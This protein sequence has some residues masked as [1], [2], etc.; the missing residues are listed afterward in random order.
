MSRSPS[1]IPWASSAAAC[2]RGSAGGRQGPRPPCGVLSL[3]HP[4]GDREDERARGHRLDRLGDQA[5]AL[6]DVERLG[7]D[8]LGAAEVAAVA[9]DGRQPEERR[10]A[11]LRP[12]DLVGELGARGGT[13][14]GGVPVAL[15]HRSRPREP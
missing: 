2:P 13:S 14:L 15:R 9:Q 6:A 1:V 4:P 5:G 8:R 11:D 10:E 7:E 12:A 3:L